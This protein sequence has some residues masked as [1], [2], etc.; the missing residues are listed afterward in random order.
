M[1]IQDEMQKIHKQYG[2]SEMANYRTEQLF[3]K[4][5]KE[6]LIELGFEDVRIGCVKD[7]GATKPSTGKNKFCLGCGSALVIY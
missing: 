6:K 7:C 4:F 2:V 3:D 5:L 1:N